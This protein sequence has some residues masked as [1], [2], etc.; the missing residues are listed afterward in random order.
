[1]DIYNQFQSIVVEATANLRQSFEKV[2]AANELELHTSRA[3]IAQ[4]DNQ[5]Q[6]LLQQIHEL[7]RNASDDQQR[8]TEMGRKLVQLSE[9]KK[10]VVSS[11]FIGQETEQRSTDVSQSFE[12]V[13]KH[14]QFGADANAMGN[15][16]FSR[17]NESLAGQA[18]LGVKPQSPKRDQER[19]I[20]SDSVSTL[21]QVASRQHDILPVDAQYESKGN[22]EGVHIEPGSVFGSTEEIFR[23]G[24]QNLTPN[25]KTNSIDGRD[26]FKMARS[27]L[28]YNEFTALLWN[29]KAFNNREQTKQ[30]MLQNLDS[31][32]APQHR[33]LLERFEKMIESE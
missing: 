6:V 1:M 11:L 3:Q 27:T 31:L 17:S 29:V 5:I 21:N 24:L 20:I 30:K 12:N 23:Q 7:Q 4:R 2:L 16:R 8:M 26:F 18:Q 9:F 10:S 13:F 15:D 32:I 25:Q 19:S 33:Y 28:S 14:S 22:T